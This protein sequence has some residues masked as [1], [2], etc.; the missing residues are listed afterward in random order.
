M[1]DLFSFSWLSIFVSFNFFKTLLETSGYSYFF[2]LTSPLH[3]YSKG[4]SMNL[5]KW[6]DKKEYYDYG[7]YTTEQHMLIEYIRFYH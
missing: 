3:F 1:Y 2:S 5:K 4:S 6:K 7:Q